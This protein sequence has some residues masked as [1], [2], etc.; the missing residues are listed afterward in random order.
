MG[1]IVKFPAKSNL[2]KPATLAVTKMCGI[3]IAPKVAG[4]VLNPY[5]ESQM[6]LLR[7][8]LVILIWFLSRESI[9]VCIT[10][11]SCVSYLLTRI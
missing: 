4:A 2:K 10:E 5:S 11:S 9:R 6:H 7:T 3:D 1:S 8:I